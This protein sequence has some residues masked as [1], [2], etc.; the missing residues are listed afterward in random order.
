MILFLM[1]GSVDADLS[2]KKNPRFKIIKMPSNTP[3]IPKIVKLNV[4]LIF[5]QN[6]YYKIIPSNRVISSLE[7][8]FGIVG[9]TFVL[10]LEPLFMKI[11]NLCKNHLLMA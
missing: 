7:G 3:R 9:D 2:R 8:K 11:S 10:V 5:K 6:F 4:N 1:S